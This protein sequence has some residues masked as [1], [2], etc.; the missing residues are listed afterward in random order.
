MYPAPGAAADRSQ[1]HSR[2][3]DHRHR[4]ASRSANCARGRPDRTRRRRLSRHR[5]AAASFEESPNLGQLKGLHVARRPARRTA[6]PA[7]S[8]CR[9]CAINDA[10]ALAA[11]I[12]ATHETHGRPGPRL[13][14]RRRHRLRPPSAQRRRLGGGPHGGHARS[15]G[16]LSAA[17]AASATWKASWAIAPCACAFWIWS[18]RKSSPP[19]ATAIRAP[20]SS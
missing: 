3:R 13:V 11:G 8:T 20:A 19:P 9:S 17:A 14:P 7:A 15:Q 5:S 2:R 18:R 10:D 1:D 6:R 12:A 16:A 4:A